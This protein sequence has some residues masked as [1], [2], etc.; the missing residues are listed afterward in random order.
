M[1]FTLTF[2]IIFLI[3]AIANF[4]NNMI[5]LSVLFKQNKKGVRKNDFK[6][7]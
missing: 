7:K 2:I 5:L 6:T 4:I 1:N 3:L